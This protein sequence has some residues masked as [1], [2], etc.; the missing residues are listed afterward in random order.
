M[1]WDNHDNIVIIRFLKRRD[2]FPNYG[3]KE[4]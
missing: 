1:V 2:F 4:T 3:Q